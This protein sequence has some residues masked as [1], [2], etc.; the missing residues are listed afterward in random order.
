MS[1]AASGALA[2]RIALVTGASRGIGRATAEH[3]ARIR[4]DTYVGMVFSNLVAICIVVA[5]T[6]ER[7]SGWI[8]LAQR[9]GC[10]ANSPQG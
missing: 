3:L 5:I 4:L 2:G 1:D 8:R 6:S 9:L 7:S 10:V